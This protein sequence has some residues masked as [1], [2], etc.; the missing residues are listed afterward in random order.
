MVLNTRHTGIV[1]TDIKRAT[2]FY[3]G[4]GMKL[5]STKIE[6]GKYIDE[7]VGLGD[8]NLEWAKLILPD[9]SV[10]ELL[11]YHSHNTGNNPTP[12]AIQPANRL[13][14][15]HIAFSVRN[16]DEVITYVKANEGYIRGNYLFSPDGNVKVIYAYDIDGNILELVEEIKK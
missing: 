11:Q 3:V 4:L 1:V 12:R 2:K 6:T 13:G 10:V 14:C 15:S 5:I 9:N 16:I 8:V 7:L